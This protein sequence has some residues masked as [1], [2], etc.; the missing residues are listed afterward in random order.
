MHWLIPFTPGGH[1]LPDRTSPG[2]IET[3]ARVKSVHTDYCASSGSCLWLGVRVRG[4]EISSDLLRDFCRG[5]G[6]LQSFTLLASPQQNGVAE[7]RIGL[8]M[9]VAHTSMIHAAAP[10]FLWPFA[11]RYAE[12]QLNLWP[13]VSIPETSP[14]LRWMG[15]VG[16]ALVFQVW[17]SRALVRDTSAD[18]LSS[19]AIPCVFLGFPLDAPGC[20]FYH[21]TLRRILSPLTSRFPFTVSSPTVPPLSP[22]CRSSLLQ[23]PLS[24]AQGAASRCAEP[25]GAEPGGAEPG[26]AEPERVE[27]GGAEPECAEPGGAEPGGAEPGVLE[28]LVLEVLELPE[29]PILVV[30]VV[31][32][33]LAPEVLVLEVPEVLV[34]EVPEV[35]PHH[36]SY[37]SG[38]LSGPAF[39]VALLELEALR[40]ETRGLEVPEELVLEVLVLEVLELPELVVLLVLEVLM[41]LAR[42]VPMVL[43]LELEALEL[44]ALELE[45]LELEVLELE[46]LELEALELEALELVTRELEVLELEALELEALELEAV[47]L[48][49]R[50]F[51]VLDLEALEI[52]ALE[53]EVSEQLEALEL[54]I[55]A[56]EVLVPKELVLVVLHSRNCSSLRRHRR[57]C[58]Q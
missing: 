20:Q 52:E 41:V 12:H 14:I 15:K 28:V 16:D 47:A 2:H 49:T 4:G 57:L 29:L 9:E 54:L 27:C 35:L 40:L 33:L 6:I 19:R 48:V 46:A 37:A 51:E 23:I 7:R 24:A 38:T 3:S 1:V 58:R 5:E 36:S 25:G 13:R 42:L 39:G 21:P 26:G 44:E 11:V 50:E 45:A 22:P 10:H 32:S 55:L 43:V 18:K 53:L 30:Q 31:L 8:V 17:G 34:L 56:L